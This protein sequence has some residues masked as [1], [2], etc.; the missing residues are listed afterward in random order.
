[1]STVRK[2][3]TGGTR[4]SVGEADQVIQKLL[5]APSGLSEIYNLFL[6]EDPVVAM[7]ASYVA[8]R[9]A[10]Q[11]PES[12]E[13]F[14]KE[15]LKNLELY[16]QQEVR[17]H[18]PQLLVH[19]NLTKTQKRR[20]YEVVMNWAETDKSKIVGYYGFQAAAD[21]AETDEDLLEDFIPRIRRANKTG[22]KSIQNRCKK[23]AKQLDIAL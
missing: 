21:F 15:L 23:I 13:P 10:E 9:V 6:D 8:M 14:A 16:T 20:A 7:R 5:K 22:A 17:W 11:K 18:I 12:V 1:M 19:L 3:L 4:T 2:L